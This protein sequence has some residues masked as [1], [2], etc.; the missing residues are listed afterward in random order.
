VSTAIQ[1]VVDSHVH[2]WKLELAQR[3][4]ITRDFGPL[5]NTFEPADLL[6]AARAVG[7]SKFVVVEAG[8][9]AEE[10]AAL[11]DTATSHEAIAAFMLFADLESLTLGR[12]LDSWLLNTKF[13][14]VRMRFE[15][16]PD[17]DI[18]K[19]PTIIAGLKQLA[20][21]KLRFEFLVRLGHLEDVL[22][23]YQQ[24]PDLLGVIE[25]MAKPVMTEG[26]ERREWQKRM[27]ALARYTPVFCKLS[28]SPRSEQF[29]A[30]LADPVSHQWSV[31]LIK[32]CVQFLLENFGPPR[33]MWGSDWPVSR[34]N[35]TYASVFQ[36]MRQAIGPMDTHH[37]NSLYRNTATQFYAL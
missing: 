27:S 18:L 5:F 1:G 6:E 30:I 28:L 16:H 35:S 34:I 29:R 13:R 17:P 19:R 36:V 2:L 26:W 31:E 33:L 25:H 23:L 11:T 12:D 15:G 8:M 4:G 22:N 10:N 24:I 3:A 32:P 20:Q 37:E 7:V 9:T 14:G 21:R